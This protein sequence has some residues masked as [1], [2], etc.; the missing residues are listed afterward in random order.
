MPAQPHA[1]QLRRLAARS[2][3]LEVHMRKTRCLF[4]SIFEHAL[5]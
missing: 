4:D 3:A 5:I 1:Q 2:P